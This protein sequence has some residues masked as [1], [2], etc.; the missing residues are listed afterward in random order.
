MRDDTS[1]AAGRL[2]GLEAYLGAGDE[3]EHRL[4]VGDAAVELAGH[5]G[6]G[7]SIEFSGRITCRNCGAD[8][9]RSYGEGH[10][11]PCFKRLARCDL[12][13][14][15]PDRCHYHYG[16]CREPEWGTRFC[17]HPHF[18]YLANSAG[19]KV[20]ITRDGH[21]PGRWIEQGATQGL[22][23]MRARTRHQAGC[24]EAALR[25]YVADRTDTRALLRGD[26]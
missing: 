25:R 5:R 17:M 6:E 21:L 13:V 26:E 18:V 22:V 20:G 3:V 9:L 14:V 2:D 8:T 15:S 16:T 24:I 12:C 10:C 23:V 7:V 11:Y 19:L 1:F 4:W